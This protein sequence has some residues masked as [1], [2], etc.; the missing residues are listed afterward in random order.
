MAVA[1]PAPGRLLSQA[2]YSGSAPPLITYPSMRHAQPIIAANEYSDCEPVDAGQTFR[3]QVRYNAAPGAV[4]TIEFASTP[5]FADVFTLDT[6]PAGAD[7]LAIWT[8]AQDVQYSG[9]IRIKNTST[10]QINAV[11]VQQQYASVG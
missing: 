10:A 5:T 6:I 3:L 7:T 1:Y 4:T 11:Y 2:T 9:F 8:T